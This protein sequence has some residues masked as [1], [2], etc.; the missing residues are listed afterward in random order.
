MCNSNMSFS[1]PNRSVLGVTARGR[2]IK[3]AQTRAYAAVDKIDWK[4]GFCRR[5]IGWR[6][7]VHKASYNALR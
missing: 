5:D 2:D 6:A 3:Q 7:L 1:L 4:G